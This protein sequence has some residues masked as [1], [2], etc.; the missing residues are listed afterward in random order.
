MVVSE[1]EHPER[2][3]SKPPT[4]VRVV[5]VDALPPLPSC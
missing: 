3:Q 1:L 2:K 4:K 5:S